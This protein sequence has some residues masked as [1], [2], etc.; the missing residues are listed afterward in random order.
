MKE[1]LGRKER[2][3][4]PGIETPGIPAQK[5]VKSFLKNLLALTGLASIITMLGS[6]AYVD[7]KL[8]DVSNG[9][10]YGPARHLEYLSALLHSFSRSIDV[11]AADTH[12]KVCDEENRKYDRLEDEREKAWSAAR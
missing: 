7:K 10:K 9:Y 6:L 1:D 5:M 12:R 3:V 4:P 8:H 11:I 2:A